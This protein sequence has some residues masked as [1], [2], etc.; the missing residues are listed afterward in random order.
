MLHFLA[1]VIAPVKTRRPQEGE[2]GTI[3]NVDGFGR[4]VYQQS[5][6]K[7]EG[8]A[9]LSSPRDLP[10]PTEKY[11]PKHREGS[12]S[13]CILI[14]TDLGLSSQRRLVISCVTLEKSLHLSEPWSSHMYNLMTMIT[15]MSDWLTL[16]V[17]GGA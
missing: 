9:P 3:S 15:T 7:T 6:C 11:R 5:L 14:S 4:T 1:R 10:I 16:F 8:R 13:H 12:T 2:Q 17:A